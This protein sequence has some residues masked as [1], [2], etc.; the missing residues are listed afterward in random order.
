[1]ILYN[2]IKLVSDLYFTFYTD[3]AVFRWHRLPNTVKHIRIFPSVGEKGENRIPL[4]VWIGFGLDYRTNF[5]L[6]V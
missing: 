1:M 3:G 4:I 5:E 2:R 6:E